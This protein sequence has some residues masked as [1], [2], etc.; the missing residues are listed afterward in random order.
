[1]TTAGT[2]AA[3]LLALKVLCTFACTGGGNITPAEAATCSFTANYS[4]VGD[5]GS[6]Y[7]QKDQFTNASAA[8]AN[9]VVGYGSKQWS[10]FPFTA[11]S[12]Y[13]LTAASAY[14]STVGKP[15]SDHVAYIYSDS[16]SNTPGT[17]ISGP[18]ANVPISAISSKGG[19]VQFN[20]LNASLTADTKYWLVIKRVS[21]VTDWSN[22]VNWWAWGAASVSDT[23][24]GSTDGITWGA[25]NQWVSGT[26][27]TFVSAP[28]SPSTP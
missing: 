15:T 22:Y 2:N 21:K 16:G 28:A 4:F 18:S 26:I 24:A 3:V 8:A 25:S 12:S 27:T 14:L 20:G 1:M 9:G 6:G 7:T 17:A 23:E 19:W 10:A 5:Q 13:T 11:G